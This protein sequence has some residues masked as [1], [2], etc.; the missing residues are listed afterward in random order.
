[1]DIPA[2]YLDKIR[3]AYPHLSFDHLDFNRDGMVNDVV[4]VNR[5]LVF[6]FA[7]EDWRKE[8]LSRE[9]R[10]LEVV[11][12]YVDL[13]VPHFEGIE[14]GFVV[15]RYLKGQPLSRN[16]VLK[17]SETS[18]NRIISQLATFLCQLHNIPT[19]VL[20][21]AGV[22]SSGA[23][24]SREDWLQ[25]YAQVQE[26]LFPYL[27]NHQQ[28]WVHELFAP[29]A[30]GELDLSYK[31]VLIHGDLALDH[32]LFDAVSESISGVID[33]GTAGFGDRSCDIAV[34]LCNY[35]E[36]IV[37]RMEKDYPLLREV[38]DRSRF[39][40][41][42]IE[43]QWALAGMKYND[44]SLSLAHIGLAREIQPVGTLT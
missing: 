8:M 5:E 30:S 3:T 24:R 26:T 19:K 38:I 20:T 39:W 18:Q 37:W 33:F 27:W 44:P 35:G 28:T 22:S 13:P 12:R 7:R 23:K 10:V 21:E 14:D 17:L 1:M 11:Q 15:Y 43:L 32:I 6:R 9:V 16:T 40:A 41:G 29:V 34:Q 25:L 2:P 36:G 42:T 4:I 31:P